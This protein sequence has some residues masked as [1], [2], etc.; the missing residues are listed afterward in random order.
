MY[1]LLFVT[2]LLGQYRYNSGYNYG[3]S[4]GKSVLRLALYYVP[5]K[6]LGKQ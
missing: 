2:H 1:R 4:S 3:Y 5:M 6:S